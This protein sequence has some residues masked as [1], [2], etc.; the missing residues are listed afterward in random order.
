M[1]ALRCAL[2]A[3]MMEGRLTDTLYLGDVSTGVSI[4]NIITVSTIRLWSLGALKVSEIAQLQL[5]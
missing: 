3:S 2:C 4:S 5:P 1:G